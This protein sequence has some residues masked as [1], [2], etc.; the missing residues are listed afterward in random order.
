[1]GKPISGKPTNESSP[2]LRDGDLRVL[3][4]A[5]NK[6]SETEESHAPD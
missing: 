6:R 2:E 1:M 5:G 4:L 3:K